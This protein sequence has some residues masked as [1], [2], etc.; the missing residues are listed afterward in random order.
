MTNKR[1]ITRKR[2]MLIVQLKKEKDAVMIFTKKEMK[3]ELKNIVDKW[4]NPET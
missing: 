1:G 4:I 3:S 2:D